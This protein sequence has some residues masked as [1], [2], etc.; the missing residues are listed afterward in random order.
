MVGTIHLAN[1]FFT[2]AASSK[3]R[4]VLLLKSNS[5]S[6]YLFMP[7]TSNLRTKGISIN[8]SNL[9]FGHLPKASVI[10]F[11]KPGVI[12]TSRLIKKIGSLKADS[13]K[14]VVEAFI[15]FIQE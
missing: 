4:P 14:N 2:D 8:N 6:D 7:L 10:V 11:E 5:F 12:A 3:I 1:I 9:S 13:Y 15:E